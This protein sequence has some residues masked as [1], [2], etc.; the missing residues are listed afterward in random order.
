MKDRVSLEGKGRERVAEV[1]ARM[2]TLGLD[3]LKKGAKLR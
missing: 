3:A 1:T 2:S